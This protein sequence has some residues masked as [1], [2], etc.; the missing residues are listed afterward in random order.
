MYTEQSVPEEINIVILYEPQSIEVPTISEHLKSFGVFSSATVSYLPATQGL[1]CKVD[2][3][4]FDVIII[5]YSVR[6]S[7]NEGNYMLSQCYQDA[8]KSFKGYKILFI[9][10]EYEGTE[11]ARKWITTLGI[12]TVYTCVPKEYIEKVYPKA[13]FPNV[14]F[15]STL[16][17]YVPLSLKDLNSYKR[18]SERSIMIGYRGR[19]LPYW[20]G[21]LGQEK[22]NIGKYIKE[23]C[24]VNGYKVDIEWDDS[25]RIYSGWYDFLG[26]CKA[27]LGTESGSNLFDF[28]GSVRRRIEEKLAQNPSLTYEELYEVCIAP[29]ETIK[30]NQISPKIFESIALKTALILFE[31]NYSGV[32]KPYIHYLPLK[33]DFSN[34]EEIFC[35]LRNDQ[36]IQGLVDQAYK[37]TI[38][39]GKYSYKQ[40]I[41]EIDDYIYSKLKKHSADR[42]I[43]YSYS[44]YITNNEFC[45]NS[46]SQSGILLPSS[47]ILSMTQ[48][49]N[50]LEPSFKRKTIRSFLN[51]TCIKTEFLQNLTFWELGKVFIFKAINLLIDSVKKILPSQLKLSIKKLLLI[52]L[53]KKPECL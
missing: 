30:M 44:G 48:I 5:H 38:E 16:T 47:K 41:K 2:L 27:T 3:N 51:D 6:L 19:V 50:T 13:R 22:K 17:G 25:K 18:T 14:E 23:Y 4:I 26:E 31:G 49:S 33:K 32:L 11:I 24:L 36:F 46:F 52:L 28:D 53:N 9:Q 20:Y 37:D 39:S 8:V 1:S 34:I 29:Y 42:K 21:S 35:R 7:V 43:I 12:N 10:D 15:L 45:L 40:F